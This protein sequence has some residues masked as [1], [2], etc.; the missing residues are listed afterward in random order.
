[1]KAHLY[2]SKK[3][4]FDGKYFSAFFFSLQFFDYV[5]HSFNFFLE[6][7]TSQYGVN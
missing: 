6:E 7:E 4:K 5:K 3:G 2:D 1:M